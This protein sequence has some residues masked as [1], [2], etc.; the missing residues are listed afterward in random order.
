MQGITSPRNLNE[1]IGSMRPES[2]E[3][4]SSAHPNDVQVS[5]VQRHWAPK[6]GLPQT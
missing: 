4:K 1:L 3:S 2:C 6:N 5:R